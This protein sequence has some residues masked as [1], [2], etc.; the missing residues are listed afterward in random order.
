ML[1]LTR[2][3][4]QSIKIDGNIEIKILK[5]RGNQVRIGIE[6]PVEVEV[7]RGEL[8]RSGK[9]EQCKSVN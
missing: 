9:V 2:K 4:E 1:V 6:A 5:V 7:L 3:P 8:E